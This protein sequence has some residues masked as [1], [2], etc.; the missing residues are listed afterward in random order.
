M[1]F[2]SAKIDMKS[3]ENLHLGSR[4][5]LRDGSEGVVYGLSYGCVG[6]VVDSGS[7]LV[8]WEELA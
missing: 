2:V 4:V 5:R 3:K 6:L 7:R 8:G 1:E